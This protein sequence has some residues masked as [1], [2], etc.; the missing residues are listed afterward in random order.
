[1]KALIIGNWKMN[2][3]TYREAKKLL[4]ATRKAAEKTKRSVVVAPPAVFLRDLRGAY[5]GKRI[6]FAAQDCSVYGAGAHTGELS[7]SQLKD[8]GAAYVIV[9]HSERRAALESDENVGKKM[10]AVLDAKLSPI[11]CVGERERH[12]SGAHL[13]FVRDQLRAAFKDVEAKELSRVIVAYEPVWAIG[14]EEAMQ[15]R[16]IHEMA[17]FIRKTLVERYDLQ[18]VA[19][20]KI[21][22][23][24]ST[25]E[26]NV[27]DILRD[28]DVAG[29]LPGHVSIDAARF[30]KLLQAVSAK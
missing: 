8:A 12:A 1:M 27:R 24:G 30:T 7:V 15:P 5:R 20:L 21:I 23:G 14:K 2:P 4:D 3:A 22:Y 11:L 28:G 10:R 18:A 6:A 17:I 13:S 16:I 9:G 19:S 25:T 29:V 26:D